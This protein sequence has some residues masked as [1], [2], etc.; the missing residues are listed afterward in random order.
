MFS[1][2]LLLQAVTTVGPPAAMQPAPFQPVPIKPIRTP[3]C[4]ATADGEI[5][6]CQSVDQNAQFRL[7]PLPEKY[8]QPTRVVVPI[9]GSATVSPN[10]AQGRLGEGQILL[11]VKIP[12]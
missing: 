12:F 11:T 4:P 10:I 5:V 9:G 7:R 3:S 1:M 6:V 8:R 2:L